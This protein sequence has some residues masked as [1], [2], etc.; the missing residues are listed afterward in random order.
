[1]MSIALKSGGKRV[2]DFFGFLW[3][4]EGGSADCRKKRRVDSEGR[5]H[6]SGV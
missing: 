1:M 6:N 3:Y 2:V 4:C 5:I